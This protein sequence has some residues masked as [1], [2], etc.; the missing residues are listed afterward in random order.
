[1]YT[2][3]SK[4]AVLHGPDPGTAKDQRARLAGEIAV[5]VHDV[6]SSKCFAIAAKGV[7]W[8]LLSLFLAV[9]F[10]AATV[11]MVKQNLLPSAIFAG[12]VSVFLFLFGMWLISNSMQRYTD[13]LADIAVCPSGL[14]W[15]RGERQSLALWSDVADVDVAWHAPRTGQAGL[16]GAAQ[17][18]S[19]KPTIT[20]VTIK[21]HSG[22]TLTLHAATLSDIDRFA[23]TVK[24]CHAQSLQKEN[25]VKGFA[26]SFLP[27]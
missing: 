13:R 17:A 22:E 12:S 5:S 9:I 19:A 2:S 18:W 11:A 16:I 7:F 15:H 1:M 3:P 14:R 25:P 27:R 6:I 21:T 20:T 10:L 24:T 26:R 4:S 8:A 23:N